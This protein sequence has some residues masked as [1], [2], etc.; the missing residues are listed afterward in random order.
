MVK[1]SAVGNDGSGRSGFTAP[2]PSG[3]AEV[4]AGALRISG[5][6]AD[7][8]RYVEAHGSGTSL[9]D[10]IELRGLTEGLRASSSGT[11]FAGLGSVK[12]NIGHTG[13]AAGIAGFI[14][15]VNVVATGDLPAHPLF[16]RP[17]DPGVLAESPFFV[18]SEAGRTNDRDR[19]VLI[20]SM[21]L[22]GTN[23]A[24]VIAPAAV[25]HAAQRAGV[26]RRAAGAV[27]AHPH[28]AG[29]DVE[30]ARRVDRPRGGRRCR[31][32]VARGT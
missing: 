20:N 24:A 25:A 7:E 6:S 10:H 19:H 18:S 2:N 29:R 28:G 32:H 13:P 8:L 21:G 22:G 5:V 30:T 17:R 23:V 26:R 27:G 16:E 31:A 11:N 12:V 14:K 4:V 9:G 1:G 15:A 3:V